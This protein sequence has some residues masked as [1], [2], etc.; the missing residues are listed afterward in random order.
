MKNTLLYS[1]VALTLFG[2]VGR[3][4]ATTYTHV[5]AEGI[6]RDS[7]WLPIGSFMFIGGILLLIG[8]AVRQ[9]ISSRKM[10]DR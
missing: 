4:Y 8:F 10:N 1:G 7:I 2:F 5:D 9:V 6:L 3:L